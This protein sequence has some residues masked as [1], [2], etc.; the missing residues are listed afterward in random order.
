MKASYA[1]SLQSV[2]AKIMFPTTSILLGFGKHVSLC[3]LYQQQ[4]MDECFWSSRQTYVYH[5]DVDLSL[6][7]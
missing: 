1:T 2:E 7:H 5:E 3:Y 6:P 4:F